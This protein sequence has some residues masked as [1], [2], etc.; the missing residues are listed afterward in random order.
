MKSPIAFPRACGSLEP[1]LASKY[2]LHQLVDC[3]RNSLGFWILVLALVCTHGVSQTPALNMNSDM[4]FCLNI[5]DIMLAALEH[6]A[7]RTCLPHRQ[8][9][10]HS[11]IS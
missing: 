8:Q 10:L 1:M 3:I 5:I 11:G 4:C 6:E 7:S 9:H 2:P